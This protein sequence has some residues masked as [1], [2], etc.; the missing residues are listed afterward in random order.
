MGLDQE[1]ENVIVPG[2]YTKLPG[3]LFNSSGILKKTNPANFIAFFIR[4][5]YLR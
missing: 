2:M 1:A 5:V 3:R 4:Y